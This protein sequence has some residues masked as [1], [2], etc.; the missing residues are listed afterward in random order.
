MN[1][2]TERALPIIFSL[3]GSGGVIVT[4]ILAAK[5]AEK[6]NIA[7]REAKKNNNKKGMVLAFIKGYYPTL[8]VGSFTIASIISGTLIS[9][10]I[11]ISLAAT[12]IALDSSLRKY[13]SKVKELLGDKADDINKSISNDE[14]K[15]IKD[16][17]KT[18]KDELTLYYE[19]HVGFFKTTPEK[20]EYSMGKINEDIHAKCGWASLETFLRY[21]NGILLDNSKID[22]MSF[23]YGW[24][25]E[26]LSEVY[27]NQAPSD[28]LNLFIHMNKQ[29]HFDDNGVFDYF[30]ITFDKELIKLFT[31]EYMSRFTSNNYNLI[32]TYMERDTEA[33]E[34][35]YASYNN[36]YKK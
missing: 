25:L 14:Y 33:T 7:I 3:I 23:S 18:V 15:K 10:K 29:K 22:K 6:A 27:S 35:L 26:Y 16:D 24:W 21:S 11:E 34:L 32:I 2:K 9:R 36:T 1:I 28:D 17:K 31:M 20:L 8:I 13:K 5:N 19:E 4:G 30:I 12:A